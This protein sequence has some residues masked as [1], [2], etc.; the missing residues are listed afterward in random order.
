MVPE[1]FLLLGLRS[2]LDQR[3]HSQIDLYLLAKFQLHKR[4]VV[5]QFLEQIH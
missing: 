3:H 4:F 5:S 2:N 1:C